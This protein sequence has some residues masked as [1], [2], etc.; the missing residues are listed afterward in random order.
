MYVWRHAAVI[1]FIH[2]H[3]E[4]I[5]NLSEDTWRNAAVYIKYYKLYFNTTQN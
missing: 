2:L 1:L 4:H 3:C 5:A